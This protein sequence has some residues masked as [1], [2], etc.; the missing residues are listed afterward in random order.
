MLNIAGFGQQILKIGRLNFIM[1]CG[2]GGH[3]D[4]NLVDV[5][6]RTIV[7]KKTIFITSAIINF[8]QENP[9]FL[10]ILLKQ[11]VRIVRVP[12]EWGEVRAMSITAT[13][14]ICKTIA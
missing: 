6:K 8:Y 13:C 4:R 10:D 14:I 9:P 11:Q 2:R 7:A 12:Y 1:L 5:F 3:R